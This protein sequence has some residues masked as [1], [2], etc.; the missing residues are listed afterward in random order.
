LL[1]DL[2][3]SWTL[4]RQ[5]YCRPTFVYTSAF[6]GT[7]ADCSQ[8]PYCSLS[9]NGDHL[10][11]HVP[12]PSEFCRDEPWP[13]ICHSLWGTPLDILQLCLKL[14]SIAKSMHIAGSGWSISRLGG[15]ALK[16]W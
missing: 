9:D 8:F 7:N 1:R 10:R 15:T 12:T 11:D 16:G 6:L 14:Q 2:L 3:R 4:Q 13:I 5:G